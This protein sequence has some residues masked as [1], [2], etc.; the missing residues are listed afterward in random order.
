MMN[1]SQTPQH[2]PQTNNNKNRP[3]IR[4]DMDSRENTETGIEENGGKHKKED[5][6]PQGKKAG[7]KKDSDSEE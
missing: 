7:D 2:N 4:D 3:E 6:H 5:T 1:Q